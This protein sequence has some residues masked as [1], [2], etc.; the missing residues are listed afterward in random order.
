MKIINMSFLAALLLLGTDLVTR[1]AMQGLELALVLTA[2]NTVVPGRSAYPDGQE[3]FLS[4][5]LTNSQI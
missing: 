4:M 3:R 1:A 5:R 2:L